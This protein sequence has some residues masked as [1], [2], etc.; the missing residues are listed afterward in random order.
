MK[1][2]SMAL[3]PSAA[4]VVMVVFPF[5]CHTALLLSFVCTGYQLGP[6]SRSSPLLWHA[7]GVVHGGRG[8]R[9]DEGGD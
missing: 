8:G 6:L 2:Q 9:Q 5:S 7:D 3:T 4:H 1:A